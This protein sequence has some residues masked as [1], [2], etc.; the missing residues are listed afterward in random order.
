MDPKLWLDIAVFIGFFVLVIGV[1]IGMSRDEQDTSEDYFLAGR[2]LSWW[3][4]G[5]S[6]IA[7][8]IS[9]EQFIGMSGQAAMHVGLAI[10]GALGAL[11]E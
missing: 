10:D 3:L 6:L 5:F 7:A 9:S 2:G 4:T 1:G 11:T 8:N